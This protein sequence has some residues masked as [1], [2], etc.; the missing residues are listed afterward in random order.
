[1]NASIPELQHCLTT[2]SILVPYVNVVQPFAVHLFH[3][4]LGR[5]ISIASAS[6][7]V[8]SKDKV[9]ADLTGRTEELINVTSAVT[10]VNATIRC[11]KQCD[12]SRRF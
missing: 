9:R 8:G 6:I 7:D 2:V 12:D 3:L 11:T 10:D 5:V 1:M 4:I